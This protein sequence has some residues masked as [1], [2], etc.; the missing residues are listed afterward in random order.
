[1]ARSPHA[2]WR[3]DSIGPTREID[4]APPVVPH[5]HA[6]VEVISGHAVEVEHGPAFERHPHVTAARLD[7][8]DVAEARHEWPTEI[9]LTL[10]ERDLESKD[11][12]RAALL[13]QLLGRRVSGMGCR[14]WRR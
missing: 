6:V 5:A 12:D 2:R 1:M 7:A 11:R 3:W 10:P 13:R 14:P 4:N 8:S 9:D